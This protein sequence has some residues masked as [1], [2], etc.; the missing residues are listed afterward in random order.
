MRNGPLVDEL[1]ANTRGLERLQDKMASRDELQAALQAQTQEIA[2]KK[3]QG[4]T[5]KEKYVAAAVGIALLTLN[6]LH[7]AGIGH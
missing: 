3:E 6:A 5:R 4:L 2:Q 7:A 1:K